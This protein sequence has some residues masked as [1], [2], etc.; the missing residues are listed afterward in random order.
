MYMLQSIVNSTV[1]GQINLQV[2]LQPWKTKQQQQQQ[3]NNFEGVGQTFQETS[4][5]VRVS[6]V[7]YHTNNVVMGMP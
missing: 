3:Q 4:T 5:T 6:S 1:K 7:L 2:E